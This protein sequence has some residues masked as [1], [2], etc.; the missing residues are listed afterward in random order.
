MPTTLGYAEPFDEELAGDLFPSKVGGKPRWLD[1]TCPLPADQVLCDECA[2]PMPM[3]LQLSAPED[4]PAE[5][6][7]RMIY[8][9]A[10]RNGAC[11]RTDVKRC[12]RV[13]RAQLAEKNAI[14]R[15]QACDHSA[16]TSSIDDIKW[17]LAEHVKP[18]PLCA[19][20]G[21]LGNKACSKCDTRLYCSRSHQMEDWNTGHSQGCPSYK[22]PGK[23][24]L[25]NG[26]RLRHLL[27]PECVIV[28]EE[29][30]LY[31]KDDEDGDGDIDGDDEGSNSGEGVEQ[32]STSEALTKTGEDLED[33]EVD[34]DE[35][36]M[37]FQQR[38][39]RSPDQIIRYARSPDSDE[40]DKP[41]FVSNTDHPQID[42]DIPRCEQCGTSRQFEF[43]IMPQMLNHLLLDTADPASI[44]WGTLLVYSCPKNCTDG[45]HN[46]AGTLTYTPEIV[47]RQNFSSHRARLRDA[48]I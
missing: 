13:M 6:F 45:I 16:G 48:S 7:H 10:C 14:Y 24:S 39:Q 2:K 35:A 29:E 1:P 12:M 17:V 37:A 9:F 19:V 40:V 42:T 34:V 44:D 21:L 46:Q 18:A 33:L 20:C 25:D 43:Q 27:Y 23:D 4:E 38:V 36:F 5:A 31:G 3:L 30:P 11:H 28:S 41:L 8:V 32:E 26:Q 47:W 15:E 22:A